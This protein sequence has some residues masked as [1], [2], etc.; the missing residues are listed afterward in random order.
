MKS[1][2][3]SRKELN[4]SYKGVE[5]IVKLMST[6]NK[7]KQTIFAIGGLIL[8]QMVLELDTRQCAIG[9]PRRGGQ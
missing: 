6:H 8:L 5:T 7:L 3:S 4:I 2:V 1:H 9:S